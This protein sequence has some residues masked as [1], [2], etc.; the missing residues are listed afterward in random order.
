LANWLDVL[1]F[2]LL[3]AD[4]LAIKLILKTLSEDECQIVT[5]RTRVIQQYV[6]Y[7][8]AEWKVTKVPVQEFFN[9]SPKGVLF[10]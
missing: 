8:E 9:G 5:E 2:K 6:K 10:V 3:G 4:L 7:N 1:H